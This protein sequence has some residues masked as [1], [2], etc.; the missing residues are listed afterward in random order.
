MKTLL[1]RKDLHRLAV[2]PKPD[3]P[4]PTPSSTKSVEEGGSSQGRE[5]TQSPKTAAGA[6]LQIN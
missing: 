1:V 5:I 3:P 4:T 6:A 2:I